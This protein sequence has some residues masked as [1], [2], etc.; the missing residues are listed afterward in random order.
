MI[1]LRDGD[2]VAVAAHKGSLDSAAS[3]IRRFPLGR[4]HLNSRAILDGKTFHVPDIAALD[5]AEYAGAYE[6]SLRYGWKAAVVAPMMREGVAGGAILMRKTE[7]GPFT[8][9]QIMLLETFAAQAVIA[10]E[11]VRLFTEL[12]EL[13]EQQT[14]TAEILP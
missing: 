4:G 9:R 1:A 10:I 7:V 5:P 11:N 3:G 13:L 2:E 14:A 12:R 8:P 6:M